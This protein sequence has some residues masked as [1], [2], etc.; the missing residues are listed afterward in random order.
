MPN[1]RRLPLNGDPFRDYV[2]R[3]LEALGREQKTQR[4]AHRRTLRFMGEVARDVDRLTHS[5]NKLA[6]F[7][8]RRFDDVDRRLTG[9]EGGLTEVLRRLPPKR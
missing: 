7:I 6:V 3:K 5:V 1:H 8:D 2:L 9:I 4:E